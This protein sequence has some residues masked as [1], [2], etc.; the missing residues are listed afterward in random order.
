MDLPPP[1][2]VNT[3][4]VL[5]PLEVATGLEQRGSCFWKEIEGSLV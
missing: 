1:L 4:V 2:V 5:F 3:S